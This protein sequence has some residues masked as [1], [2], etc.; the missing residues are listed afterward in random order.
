MMLALIT[1]SDLCFICH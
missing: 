1:G